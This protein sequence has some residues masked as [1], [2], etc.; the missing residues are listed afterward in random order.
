MGIATIAHVHG[1]SEAGL[2]IAA[3][4]ACDISVLP[5]DFHTTLTLTNYTQAAGGIRICV[6]QEEAD[7]AHDVLASLVGRY[8]PPNLKASVVPILI[9][10]AFLAVVPPPA[11][12][13]FPT[14]STV[15][16]V[17]A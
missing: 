10:G 5:F 11:S 4:D 15:H 16:G 9:F 7:E 14:R 13:V 17:F 2:I 12:G 6:P 8:T 1:P 3:L